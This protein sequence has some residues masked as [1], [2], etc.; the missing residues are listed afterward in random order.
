MITF[1]DITIQ[2]NMQPCLVYVRTPFTG[3]DFDYTLL[4]I[5]INAL[6]IYRFGMD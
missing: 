5:L 4:G 3:S 2:S 6:F 1:N